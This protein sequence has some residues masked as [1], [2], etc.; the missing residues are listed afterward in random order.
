MTPEMLAAASHTDAG[1]TWVTAPDGQAAAFRSI[2]DQYHRKV[3]TIPWLPKDW[4]A[5][6]ERLAIAA[7][8]DQLPRI[9]SPY[10]GGSAGSG[11]I[12][13]DLPDWLN[14]TE[15]REKWQAVRDEESRILKPLYLGLIADAKKAADDSAAR[16]E[17]W[18]TVYTVTETVRDAPAIAVNAVANGAVSAIGGNLGKLFTNPATLLILALGGVYAYFRWFH[19]RR[20]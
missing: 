18:N 9:Y 13:T 14:T 7:P 16:V 8:G 12:K 10:S 19:V 11:Q 2:L 6:R 3:A 17:F 5:R 15:R 20:T 4:L 1:L